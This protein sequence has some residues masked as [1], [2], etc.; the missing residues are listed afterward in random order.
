MPEMATIRFTT[1]RLDDITRWH[2]RPGGGSDFTEGHTGYA[3]PA[4][5]A[6]H[7]ITPRPEQ[8]TRHV[9]MFGPAV[10]RDR[11]AAKKRTERLLRANGL[12]PYRVFA[13][14]ADN[15][16]GMVTIEPQGNGFMAT[17]TL[18]LDLCAK[19]G[20]GAR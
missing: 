17:I 14:D 8:G 19:A 12:D 7:V 2:P 10:G 15:H 16:P 5:T 4:L 1:K 6:A 11:D 18:T 20:E 9:L 13:E 3:V